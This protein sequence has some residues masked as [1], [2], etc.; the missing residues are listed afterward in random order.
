[1]SLFFPSLFI[2]IDLGD[3]KL[4][5]SNIELKYAREL[6]NKSFYFPYYYDE[7]PNNITDGETILSA[8][9]ARYDY[10]LLFNTSIKTHFLSLGLQYARE[11]Y[12]SLDIFSK[13]GVLLEPS[14]FEDDLE[15]IVNESSLFLTDRFT[16]F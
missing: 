12:Q 5:F 3:C 10:S 15:R 4:N 11:T 6:Y 1:M 16:V 14:I 8:L 7:Y 9:P 13:E 2:V